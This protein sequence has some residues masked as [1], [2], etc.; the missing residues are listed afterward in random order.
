MKALK[1]VTVAAVVGIIGTLALELSETR[2]EL[3]QQQK[4][5][6]NWED[7]ADF[8]NSNHIAVTTAQRSEIARL[9]QAQTNVLAAH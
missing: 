8:Q 6:R 4:A 3:R 1:I 5:N 9:Q 2:Y 7:T